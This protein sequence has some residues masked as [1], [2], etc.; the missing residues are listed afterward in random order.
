MRQKLFHLRCYLL[1]LHCCAGCR[2]VCVNPGLHVD[3]KLH[4]VLRAG[5]HRPLTACIA[6][7]LWHHVSLFWSHFI[8]WFVGVTGVLFPIHAIRGGGGG[9]LRPYFDCIQAFS[10]S[11]FFSVEALGCLHLVFQYNWRF[12]RPDIILCHD[13]WAM[14]FL[15]ASG[16]NTKY[17]S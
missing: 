3:T 16:A 10:S 14:D 4:Y 8:D 2:I 7:H 6:S 1:F 12:H 17:A 13:S 9:C 11:G 15:L 5:Q